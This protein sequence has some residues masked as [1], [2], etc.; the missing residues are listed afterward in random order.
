MITADMVAL[1]GDQVKRIYMQI[2][3]VEFSKYNCTAYFA[4]LAA[5]AALKSRY[6]IRDDQVILY[7]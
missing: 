4:L 7:G 5:L 6:N 2:L 1:V 3:Q